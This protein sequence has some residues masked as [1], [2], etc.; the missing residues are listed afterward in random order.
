MKGRRF[1]PSLKSTVTHRLAQ[2]TGNAFHKIFEAD[3]AE[4]ASQRKWT[5]NKRKRSCSCDNE[6]QGFL[7]KR[8]RVG[9]SRED[10]I[11]KHGKRTLED[12]EV[13]DLKRKKSRKIIVNCK[14]PDFV[15]INHTKSKDDMTV[16][17]FYRS[18]C[19]LDTLR[20]YFR[21]LPTTCW[22][23]YSNSLLNVLTDV[24]RIQSL[25]KEFL[26]YVIQYIACDKLENFSTKTIEPFASN[27]ADTFYNQLKNCRN[28]SSLEI[29][30]RPDGDSH[31]VKMLMAFQRLRHLQ[32][33]YLVPNTKYSYH[34]IFDEIAQHCSKLRELKILYDGDSFSAN[35]EIVVLKSC[36]SLC[37]LWL[38]NYGRKSET[39]SLAELLKTLVNLKIL[40]HKELP[41]AILDLTNNELYN[42]DH[43]NNQLTKDLCCPDSIGYLTEGSGESRQALLGLERVD[44]CWYLESIGY[45][46]IYIPTSYLLR[47]AQTCPKISL[48]NLIGSTCLSQMIAKLPNL[49]AI[50]LM[51]T[52]FALSMRCTLNN[53]C[54]EK[55]TVL[56]L[57]DVW[58]I[59]YD[60]ISYVAH[61]CINLQIL[62]ISCSSLEA[63]GRLVYPRKRPPFGQL[64]HLTLVP[65]PLE[66]RPSLTARSS[67][68]LGSELTKYLLRETS[69]L[70]FIHIYYKQDDLPI[71][72]TPTE[73][74]LEEVLCT[75]RPYL[76][77]LLLDWPPALSSD[78]VGNVVEACPDLCKLGNL[79]TW[80][81]T[82]DQR[83][84][85]ITSYG[86]VIDIS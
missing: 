54:M 85:L 59:T 70:S 56:R 58:D 63:R 66:N 15:N 3:L 24:S 48:I 47:I 69:L 80:P 9:D 33:L 7:N 20:K 23:H 57:S 40:F 72:D 55:L 46:L 81:F 38:F 78:F 52:S 8:A 51:Q 43:L 45:Q 18:D 39:K 30:F 77:S 10:N 83:A 41:N 13:V 76:Q 14:T 74:V 12:A 68:E 62:S 67:W 21:T 19:M 86:H 50:V 75:H 27:I 53:Q 11:N 84:L 49:Q 29:T 6:E 37:A 82:S 73:A 28:L 16:T 4:K 26:N 36:R 79:T 34:W 5:G 71:E 64:R 32:S 60:M 25:D 31:H 61:S 35:Q 42:E 17:Y 22:D 1:I 65:G 44:L 2:L